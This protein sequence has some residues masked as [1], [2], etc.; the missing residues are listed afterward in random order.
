[1]YLQLSSSPRMVH[2]PVRIMFNSC[3]AWRQEL[4]STCSQ[5]YGGNSITVGSHDRMIFSHKYTNICTNVLGTLRENVIC[6]ATMTHP[7]HGKRH[8]TIHVDK[9]DATS[10]RLQT[11]PGGTQ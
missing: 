4:D 7:Q 2:V 9:F 1:M 3:P 5:R 10:T 8:D 11:G 6:G